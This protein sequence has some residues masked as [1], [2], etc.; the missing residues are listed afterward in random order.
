MTRDLITDV[1]AHCVPASLRDTI[2]EDGRELGV[3]VAADGTVTVAGK[4][5]AMPLRDGLVD[6]AARLDAMDRTGVD[7]QILSPW[8]DLVAYRLDA[9]PGARWSRLLNESLADE[10]ATRPDR[11]KAIGT[12]P[13]QA[14]DLAAAELRYA[15]EVLG[16]VGVEIGTRVGDVDLVSSGLDA[17]WAEADRLGCFILLHPLEPLAGIDLSDRMLHN[18]AGRP[19]E[20]TIA[21]S[22]LLLAGVVENHPAM[23]LCAVHGGGFLPYQIGRMQR[24]WEARPDV[25]G[26]DLAMTPTEA[27]R[28][29]YFDTVLNDPAAIRYLIDRVG[30]DR[31]LLG[32]DY[33]FEMGDPDPIATLLAV[34][35]LDAGERTAVLSG[36]A[37]RLFSVGP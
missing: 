27:L 37:G 6:R 14:P 22:R 15:V 25:V 19:A 31:V 11:F 24:G 33:P 28:S 16:M 23:A 17:V 2:A 29:V 30:A 35:G 10:A 36:N 20:T 26:T 13:L 1:H 32:S 3:T 5:V 4:A 18:I 12:V 21:L 8:I 9:E 7:L 34:P